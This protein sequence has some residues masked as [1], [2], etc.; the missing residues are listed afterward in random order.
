ARNGQ[1]LPGKI[2][3][4]ELMAG[5]TLLL[6]AHPSFEQVQRNSRDFY[7]VSRIEDSAPPRHERA[8]TARTI[9][10][11]MVLL[12]AVGGMSMLKA[13]LLAT[14]AMILSRCARGRE[15]RRAIDWSVLITMA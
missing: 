6:E 8:W 14:A 10:V 7:L 2:G 5:D 3:D 1:R 12:V 9:L 15:M 11:L 13:S 4:I